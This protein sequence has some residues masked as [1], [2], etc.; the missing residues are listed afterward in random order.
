MYYFS[1][2]SLFCSGLMK[3]LGALS[4]N[5]VSLVHLISLVV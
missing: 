5:L 4:A 1:E 2:V 3:D